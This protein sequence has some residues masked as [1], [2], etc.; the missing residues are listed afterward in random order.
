MQSNAFNIQAGGSATLPCS[1]TMVAYESGQS[2]T[3]NNY[4]IIRGD[5]QSEMRLKPGQS[6]TGTTAS[7]T[8]YIHADDSTAA[9][10]GRV[11][12]GDGE[13]HDSAINAT[14][15]GAV[16]VTNTVTTTVGNTNAQA[17][18]T[19]MQA[20]A[21]IT[22]EAAVTITTANTIQP[23]ISDPTQRIL[24]IRNGNATGNLYIGSSTLTIAN[25]AIVLA[26]GDLW[27]E[28]EAAGAAWYAISD[29]AGMIVQIQGLKQ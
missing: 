5:G 14:I 9:I 12:I 18:P 28:Q 11:I 17:I 2:T 27:I 24:R 7:G 16:Q 6:F 3:G 1:G 19:Q 8:W 10:V 21:T 26:P 15:A 23:L 13:F 4:I 20:L 25:A 29:T 22:D